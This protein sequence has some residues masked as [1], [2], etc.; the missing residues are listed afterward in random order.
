MEWSRPPITGMVGNWAL[1]TRSGVGA[2]QQSRLGRPGEQ[3]HIA[4]IKVKCGF[5]LLWQ[6]W[7]HS[8]QTWSFK[9]VQ[10]GL[11]RMQCNSYFWISFRSLTWCLSNP[12]MY[13]RSM[14]LTV[15]VPSVGF[16]SHAEPGGGET[17]RWEELSC[18]IPHSLSHC[19][20]RSIGLWSR[21]RPAD[22]PRLER[23]DLISPWFSPDLAWFYHQQPDWPLLS[24]PTL[25]LDW[26]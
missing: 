11:R 3:I 10:K 15:G 9:T 7:F 20:S 21:R 12:W 23:A 24:V 2:L 26:K 8:K 16:S 17:R 6:I 19:S 22:T 5:F 14:D 1:R 18:G 25:N 13:F 4:A